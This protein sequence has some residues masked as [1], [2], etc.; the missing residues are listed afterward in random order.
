MNTLT[1][2]ALAMVLAGSVTFSFTN[3]WLIEQSSKF[4]TK[5]NAFILSKVQK[6]EDVISQKEKTVKDQTLTANVKDD[7]SK[8]SQDIPASQAADKNNNNH[9]AEAA[10]QQ[11]TKKISKSSTTAPVSKTMPVKSSKAPAAKP[12]TTATG[13]KTAKAPEVNETSPSVVNTT[14]PKAPEVNQ[15]SPKTPKTKTEIKPAGTSPNSAAATA[16]NRGQEVSQAAKEN[17]AS[18][19]DTK[20]NNGKNM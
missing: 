6:K 13:T 3:S 7:Q 4:L 10:V 9:L 8:L 14:S 5:E 15:T 2:G 19:R 16:N 1:K 20:E 18:A 11:D 12:S 17:A